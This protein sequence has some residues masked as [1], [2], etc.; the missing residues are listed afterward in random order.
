MM[1]DAGRMAE[2]LARALPELG[3]REREALM[4]ENQASHAAARSHVVALAED[5]EIEGGQP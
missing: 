1:T 3:E 5:A 2:H 4:F